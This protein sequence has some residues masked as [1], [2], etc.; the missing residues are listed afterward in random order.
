MFIDSSKQSLKCE[1]QHNDNKYGSLITGHSTK[2]AE[3]QKTIT[4]VLLKIY[5]NHQWLICM[6]Q[7]M[8]NFLLGL[9]SGYVKYPCF[10]CLW[11]SRSKDEF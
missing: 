5:Y 4:L 8:V 3:E 1:L 9:Q 2:M 6:D 7:I 11:I 10:I